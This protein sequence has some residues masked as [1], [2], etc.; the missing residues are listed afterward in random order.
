MF[1]LLCSVQDRPHF[2]MGEHQRLL[3]RHLDC[4][5]HCPD[6]TCSGGKFSKSTT[7]AKSSSVLR[8][9]ARYRYNMV[10]LSLDFRHHWGVADF[11]FFRS[12]AGNACWQLPLK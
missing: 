12:Q 10:M 1:E 5:R 7:P 4:C 6:L 3:N 8:A 2:S 11:N 9:R